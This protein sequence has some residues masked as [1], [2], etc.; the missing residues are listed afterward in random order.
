MGSWALF[1]A[2]YRPASLPTGHAPRSV[3]L[4]MACA[5]TTS[6]M[7]GGCAD[8][9]AERLPQTLQEWSRT[10]SR[11]QRQ[12]WRLRLAGRPYSARVFS[13]LHHPQQQQQRRLAVRVIILRHP[14]SNSR[15]LMIAC[16]RLT[17]VNPCNWCRAIFELVNYCFVIR[18]S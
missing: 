14:L 13:C 1:V 8:S 4:S 15:W 10:V 11:G 7:S 12:A 16:C 2:C 18:Y 17:A 9:V 5:K 6:K 3:K